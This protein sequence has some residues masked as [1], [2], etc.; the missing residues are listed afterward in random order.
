MP[1]QDVQRVLWLAV[2]FLAV[3]LPSDITRIDFITHRPRPP[4]HTSLK[5]RLAA[6]A[7]PI[8]ITGPL[9]FSSPFGDRLIDQRMARLAQPGKTAEDLWRY[10]S[11]ISAVVGPPIEIT[12]L[13]IA[14][15]VCILAIAFAARWMLWFLRKVMWRIATHAKGAWAA[16]VVLTTVILSIFDALLKSRQ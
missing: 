15:L 1:R 9:D 2:V 14:L 8:E 12:L 16:I 7:S 5:P 3:R 13:D 6:R 11:V 4:V 10:D